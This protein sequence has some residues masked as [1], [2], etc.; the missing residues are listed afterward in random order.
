[1]NE[2]CLCCGSKSLIPNGTVI[3]RAAFELGRLEVGLPST[4]KSW[5]K[6]PAAGVSAMIC[7][8]CGFVELHAA[9]VAQI[10]GPYRP[11]VRAVVDEARSKGGTPAIASCPQCL[12]L[13]TEGLA[14]G[15]CGWS[16]EAAARS[17]GTA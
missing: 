1:M 4:P 11:K 8:A 2:T 5:L 9:D 6:T 12:A 17:D 14:C 10:V 16:Y 3:S 15:V 7:S 13:L